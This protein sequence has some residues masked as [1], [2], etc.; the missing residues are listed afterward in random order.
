MKK[1]A[2]IVGSGLVGSLWA[3]YLANEGYEVKVFERRADLRK[4]A[5]SAGKSINL[6][7]SYRGWKALDAIGIG[8]EVRK[9]AIPMYGR[10]MH[11]LEGKI[12]YQPYGIN[13]QAIFI[14]L[15]L[16]CSGHQSFSVGT[17]CKRT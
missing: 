6:A 16:K 5:I 17:K 2:T 14:G 4:A 13:N 15:K 8:D 11:D 12:T 10:T 1:Q 9:I 3:V 7:T